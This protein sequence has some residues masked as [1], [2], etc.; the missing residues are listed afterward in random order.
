MAEK[1][2]TPRPIFTKPAGESERLWNNMT[3]KTYRAVTCQLC[4]TELPKPSPDEG[5]TLGRFLGLQFVEECCGRA[6]DILYQEFGETFAMAFLNDFSENPSDPRFGF[7]T[8]YMP[9]IFTKAKQKIDEV[10][11]QIALAQAQL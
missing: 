4:G 3:A 10:N 6:V 5:Y 7:L 11:R 2:L 8:F 1:D 9:D